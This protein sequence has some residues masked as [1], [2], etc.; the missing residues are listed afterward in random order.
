MTLQQQRKY[1]KG[2]FDHLHFPDHNLFVKKTV[3]Y[4]NECDFWMNSR[5]I[6]FVGYKFLNWNGTAK[7]HKSDM[8]YLFLDESIWVFVVSFEHTCTIT[9]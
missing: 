9:Y 7:Y 6:I 1:Q 2:E 5:S 8:D 4:R 3:E